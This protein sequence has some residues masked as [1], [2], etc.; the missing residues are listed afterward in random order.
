MS[1]MD[2]GWKPKKTD[3]P[4]TA[5]SNVGEDKMHYPSLY[6]DKKVPQELLDKDVG[7]MCRLEVVGRIKSKSID[8]RGKPER[9]RGV[10][11]PLQNQVKKF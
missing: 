9:R 10:M 3:M 5:P 8:E 6:I 7:E 11:C 1:L 2:M 4:E